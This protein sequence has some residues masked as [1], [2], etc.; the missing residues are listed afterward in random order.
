MISKV[1]IAVF[2]V[3][4]DNLI[5]MV[6]NRVVGR[7]NKLPFI[8]LVAKFLMAIFHSPGSFALFSQMTSFQICRIN[9]A[10]M[11]GAAWLVLKNGGL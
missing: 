7:V 11:L 5:T 10:G 4:Q 8:D 3:S 6:G 2:G 1:V 9:D